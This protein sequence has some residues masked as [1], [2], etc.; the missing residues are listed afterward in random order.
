[1]SFLK[2]LVP[3]DLQYVPVSYGNLLPGRALLTTF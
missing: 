2:H 1:M 3:V